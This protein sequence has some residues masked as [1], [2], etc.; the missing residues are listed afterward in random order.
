[1][2]TYALA[3]EILEDEERRIEAYGE[4]WAEA[5]S[6]GVSLGYDGHAAASQWA[7]ENADRFQPDPRL[8]EAR[9]YVD[10][11]PVIY[12]VFPKEPG[13]FRSPEVW[14]RLGSAYLPDAERDAREAAIPF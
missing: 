2:M 12:H 3:L 5:G 4:Q 9:A 8:A 6:G 11:A 1:M 14:S 10:G 13:P 7:A